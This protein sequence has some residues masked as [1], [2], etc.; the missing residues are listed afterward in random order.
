VLLSGISTVVYLFSPSLGVNFSSGKM[1]VP[2]LF[3]AD[4]PA[5]VII[6]NM[7]YRSKNYHLKNI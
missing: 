7:L 2:Y 5:E 1:Y 6:Y 3:A 4:V